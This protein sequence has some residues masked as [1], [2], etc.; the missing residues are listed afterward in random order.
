[1]HPPS[2]SINSRKLSFSMTQPDALGALLI[3]LSLRSRT[4]GAGTSGDG[5]LWSCVFIQPRYMLCHLAC[6]SRRE[7]ALRPGPD[8]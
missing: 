4:L 8:A 7:V 5:G 2:G 3:A 6:L 1:M